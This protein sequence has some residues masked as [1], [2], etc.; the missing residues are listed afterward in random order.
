[1]A[2]TPRQNEEL[3]RLIGNRLQALLSELRRDAAR[4][5]GESFRELAGPA[6]D[7]GDASV[8]ALIADLDQADLSRD[9]GELRGLEAARGRITEGSYGTCADCGEDIRFERLRAEPGAL[10][11]IRC[12]SLHEKTFAAAGRPKL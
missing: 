7:A 4:A 3:Q 10:R 12:Q 9:L 8:A 11:C 2:L 6:P 5:R 1:M